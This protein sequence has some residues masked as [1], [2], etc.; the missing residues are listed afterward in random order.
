MEYLKKVCCSSDSVYPRQT[1]LVPIAE[2]LHIDHTKFKNR[3]LLINEIKDKCKPST[4][5]ENSTDFITLDNVDDIPKDHLFIWSQ[6]KKTFC[7]DILSL[8]KYIDSG[9]SLNPWTID[10]ATGID[11]SKNKDKYLETWD[12]KYQKGLLQKINDKYKLLGLDDTKDVQ[13]I[14]NARFDIEEISDSTGQYITHIID[15]IENIDSRLYIYIMSDILNTCFRYFTFNNNDQTIS[16]LFNSLFID[17]E[18][19]KIQINYGM[20]LNCNVDYMYKVMNSIYSNNEIYSQGPLTYF[21]II[22]DE[23]LKSYN[24]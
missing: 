11:S 23:I 21:I 22:F 1:V 10:F 20:A 17:N 3:K 12:M 4:I 5:C 18:I 2:A 8:K 15:K 14:S 19:L 16:I 9:N 6:N 24:Q 13:K 7:A